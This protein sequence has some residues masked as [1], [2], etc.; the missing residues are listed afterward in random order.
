[1]QQVYWYNEG[2]GTGIAILIEDR[3]SISQYPSPITFNYRSN[4]TFFCLDA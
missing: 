2:I 4:A 1:M 3:I